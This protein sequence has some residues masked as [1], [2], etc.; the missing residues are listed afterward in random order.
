MRARQEVLRILETAL[1]LASEGVD[2]A[3]VA[4]AGGDLGVTRFVDNQIQPAAQRSVETLSVRLRAKGQVVRVSTT[5]LATAGIKQTVMQARSIVGRLPEAQV[6]APAFPSPQNYVEI[7]A[8]DPEI[9]M[10]RSLERAA[11]VGR[12]VV[13]AHKAHLS[14]SGVMMARRGSVGFDGTLVPYALANTRGLL[15][16]HPETRAAFR[17]RM[18]SK[19]GVTGFAEA[20]SCSAEALNIERL[21]SMARDRATVGGSLRALS[22]GDYE[23][24]LEPAAVAA[25]LRF[26]GLTCGASSYHA[27][28]SF[29]SGRLGQT[30]VDARITLLDD[31]AHPLHRGCPFDVEGVAKQPVTII[32]AGVARSPVRSWLSASSFES[33]TGHQLRDGQFGDYEGAQHLVLR[34]GDETLADLIANVKDGVLIT[35]LSEVQLVDAP[36][37]RVFGMTRG[38][39]EVQGGEVV[40]PAKDLA[41]EVDVLDLL[42]RVDGLTNEV[43][44][45]GAVV[46]AMRVSGFRLAAS[47]RTTPQ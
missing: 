25:L 9:E 18:R 33:A 15:A 4:L 17:V 14:A 27:G 30:I 28:S 37:L 29:L 40:G 21:V 42:N 36:T 23:A 13:E 3:E 8:Y 16:Y 44:A 12:A 11:I 6:P 20:E 34:G 41:F 43:W 46:P 26:L 32:E 39:L 1:S 38:V 19:R 35:R 7:E 24:V 5:D 22:P 31:F 10:M 47:D 45:D 2:E